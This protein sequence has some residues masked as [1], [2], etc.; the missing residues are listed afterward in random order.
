[1]ANSSFRG[2]ATEGW[3]APEPWPWDRQKNWGAPEKSLS[4]SASVRLDMMR[5][6][7]RTGCRGLPSALSTVPGEGG[8]GSGLLKFKLIVD[9][10]DC[11]VSVSDDGD[12]D[13][14]C[15]AGWYCISL[16]ASGTRVSCYSYSYC[17][18]NLNDWSAKVR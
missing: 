18:L 16:D 5:F 15:L 11:D 12:V 13:E 9:R 10:G 4:I 2:K 17:S 8:D 3:G 6:S 1:M 14:T 7:L